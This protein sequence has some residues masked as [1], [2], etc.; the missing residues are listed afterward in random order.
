[1]SPV[2]RS[3][4]SILLSFDREQPTMRR[5]SVNRWAPPPSHRMNHTHVS[6]FKPQRSLRKFLVIS[7][8][9]L[10]SA[11]VFNSLRRVSTMRSSWLRISRSLKLFS[12]APTYTHAL[13]GGWC[14]YNA[15]PGCVCTTPTHYNRFSLY[16]CIIPCLN[17]H[18]RPRL[19]V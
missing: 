2:F 19:M 17:G 15:E 4:C 13:C 12:V 3:F 14:R 1:M 8:R 10:S 16:I 6:R 7:S 9:R 18:Y 11:Y 5:I